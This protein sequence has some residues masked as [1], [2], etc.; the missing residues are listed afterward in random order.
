MNKPWK[1]DFDR[2]EQLANEIKNM[3]E[4]ER[5]NIPTCPICGT[6]VIDGWHQ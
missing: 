1:F 6:P 3:T 5:K 4:E 2:I